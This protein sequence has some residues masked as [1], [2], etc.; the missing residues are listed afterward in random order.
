MLVKIRACFLT[1]EE[2]LYLDDISPWP[3]RVDYI[4]KWREF[5][6]QP[7]FRLL[8]IEKFIEFTFARLIKYIAQ[9]PLWEWTTTSKGSLKILSGDLFV[10]TSLYWAPVIFLELVKKEEV[11][12]HLVGGNERNVS[13][14]R[15]SK[16]T[17]ESLLNMAPVCVLSYSWIICLPQSRTSVKGHFTPSTPSKNVLS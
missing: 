14:C 12:I 1:F 13:K 6:F 10:K 5:S 3:E 11:L 2:V 17:Y 7:I 16:A 9:G 15:K 8:K 4:L